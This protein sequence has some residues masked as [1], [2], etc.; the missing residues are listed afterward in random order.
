VATDIIEAAAIAYV[1][2]LS[3]A[4]AQARAEAEHP[5]AAESELTPTP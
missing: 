2:A 5:P 1:R 3:N 4:V